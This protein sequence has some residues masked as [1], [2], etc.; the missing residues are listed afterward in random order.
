[1]DV[2]NNLRVNSIPVM[3]VLPFISI[4]FDS[5]INYFLV[6]SGPPLPVNFF[7]LLLILGALFKYGLK[8]LPIKSVFTWWMTS[9]S[10]SFV[11]GILTAPDIGL[12]RINQALGM[13]AAYFGGYLAFRWLSSEDWIAKLFI[14]I[15]GVYVVVCLLAL[16]KAAPNY[17]PLD[18]EY[19]SLEG[20]PQ[21]RPAVTTN[22]N[23]QIFYLFP[24]AVLIALPFKAIRFLFVSILIISTYYI[25][26][27]VQTRSGVAAFAGGVLLAAV[28]PLW[29]PELGRKKILFFI[30]VGV[31]GLFFVAPIILSWAELLLYRFSNDD[32]GTGR[33]RL[34]SFLYLFEH[35]WD[36]MW[37]LPRGSQEFIDRTGDFA[38]SNITSMFLNGG[39]LGLAGWLAVVCYPLIVLTKMFL[40][41]QLDSAATLVWCALVIVWV[42]QMSLDVAVQKYIWIW[43]GAGVATMERI[44][45]KRK[46]GEQATYKSN[47]RAGNRNFANLMP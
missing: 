13:L 19:W 6:R 37:W 47:L 23:F 43:A 18:V 20:V 15:V 45:R 42:T 8:V 35:L 30:A 4:F 38:H 24:C 41:R 34:I 5:L 14:S 11:I 44:Q 3:L 40:K 29:T 1:M 22:Q 28:S 12:I 27:Q 2:N 21:P 17:F 26:A 9:I 31:S 16:W 39:L 7:S 46:L 10:L 33:G 25:L 36:P 32:Y